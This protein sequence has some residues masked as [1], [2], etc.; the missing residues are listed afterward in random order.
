MQIT[1]EVITTN[2][3]ERISGKITPLEKRLSKAYAAERFGKLK[4]KPLTLTDPP[5]KPGSNHLTVVDAEGNVATVLHSVMS[6]PWSNTLFVDGVSI[7]AAVL[8]YSSGIPE[9]GQRINARIGPNIFFK[10]N[11]PVLAS[12][13]PS[14]S[15]MENVF[16]NTINILDFGIL[17]EESVHLPRFGGYSLTKPDHILIENDYDSNIIAGIEKLGMKFDKVRPWQWNLGSFEGIYIDQKTN[18]RYACGDP[19][20]AGQAKAS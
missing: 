16:Q 4:G 2:F 6:M 1:G 11:K 12:G 9:P 5:P 17:P 7:C 3:R 10:N 18:I 14:V 19:R 20:R 8:H 13:S 15:L